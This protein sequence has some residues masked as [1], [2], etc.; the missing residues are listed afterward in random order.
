MPVIT[1]ERASRGGSHL[2]FSR[3]DTEKEARGGL[4]PGDDP[5]HSSA[6]PQGGASQGQTSQT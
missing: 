4:Y 1:D 6:D 3:R 2:H 5:G